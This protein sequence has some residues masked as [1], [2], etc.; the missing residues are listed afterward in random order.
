M[1]INI[2]N[3]KDVG[4]ITDHVK[5]ANLMRAI[6]AAESEVDRDKEHF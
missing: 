3:K 6:L 4:Q 2:A 5:V 1:E